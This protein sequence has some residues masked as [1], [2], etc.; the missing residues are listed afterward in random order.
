MAGQVSVMFSLAEHLDRYLTL[1]RSLGYQLTEHGDL[2]PDFVRYAHARGESTVRTE[3]ALEWAGRAGTDGQRARRLSM[4][5]GLARYLSAFDPGTEIPLP[6]PFAGP[7][8]GTP[9]IYSEQ[10]IAGLMAAA[11]GLSPAPFA[12][13]MATL[14]GL[15]ASTGLRP[16]EIRRLDRADVD[17]PAGQI[18]VWHSK[19]GRSRRL[20]LHDSTIAALADYA[21]TRDRA[22]PRDE[23]FFPNRKGRRLTAPVLS[24]AFRELRAQASMSTPAGQRPALLGDL[25]HTFAVNTL[26]SWHRAG[27]DVQ[28]QLPALSAY[29]GHVNPAQTYW[30]LQAAPELMALIAERLQRFT[31]AQR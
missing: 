17:L 22:R 24:T 21:A 4:V 8:H 12:A 23:A 13:T 14:I 19:S 20:P 9:R 29:M 6:G 10:E 5:R 16:A 7:L 1:R 27:T 3:T 15:M 30:Y 26:I 18:T 25:R 31:E 2:L 28:A 11:S